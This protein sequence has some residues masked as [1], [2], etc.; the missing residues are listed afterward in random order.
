LLTCVAIQTA[1]PVLLGYYWMSLAIG[2]GFVG[3]WVLNWA[4]S[5]GWV[6][7]GLTQ[8]LFGFALLTV[9][10]P[11]AIYLAILD[12]WGLP[13]PLLII[14]LGVVEARDGLRLRRRAHARRPEAQ[15]LQ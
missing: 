3:G 2:G 10:L 13:L 5:S 7:V 14:P 9:A 8:L 11:F 1:V 12:P 15:P 6:P 4:E